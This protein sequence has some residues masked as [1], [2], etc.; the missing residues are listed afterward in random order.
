MI[1]FHRLIRR[2]SSFISRFIGGRLLGSTRPEAQNAPLAKSCFE[3]D[4]EQWP[5]AW[6]DLVQKGQARTKLQAGSPVEEPALTVPKREEL[7]NA[8]YR[9]NRLQGNTSP[10]PAF[11]LR[12]S[13]EKTDS[14]VCFALNENSIQKPDSI[15]LGCLSQ[16][17]AKIQSVRF[18]SVT[19]H[20]QHDDVSWSDTEGLLQAGSNTEVWRT[21]LDGSKAG[22]VSFPENKSP[23]RPEQIFEKEN[24]PQQ[25]QTLKSTGIWKNVESS[26]APSQVWGVEPTRGSQSQAASE[27]H[28]LR[29]SNVSPIGRAA[30]HSEEK[31]LVNV[32]SSSPEKKSSVRY[33]ETNWTKRM[34]RTPETLYSTF[35]DKSFWPGL[36]EPETQNEKGSRSVAFN[37]NGGRTL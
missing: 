36:I 20:A 23:S 9:E 17:P 21:E 8:L 35:A 7:P 4:P 10:K 30:V 25:G 34:L 3:T 5:K 22:V 11:E 19:E 33:G 32:P 31:E 1:G 28:F 16:G 27:N 37:S 15:R 6:A 2:F 18:D 14:Q 13:I 26:L 29:N 12:A 24:A